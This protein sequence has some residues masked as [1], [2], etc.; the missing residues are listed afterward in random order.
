MVALLVSSKMFGVG[1]EIKVSE[2]VQLAPQL[3][4]TPN[5]LCMME[6][7][8]I[9]TL[10][11]NLFVPTTVEFAQTLL[12]KFEDDCAGKGLLLAPTK[13]W[14]ATYAGYLAK[15]FVNLEYPQSEKAMVVAACAIARWSI[16]HAAI[17]SS[18]DEA[19]L[20][21]AC[22]DAMHGAVSR[23]AGRPA[24]DPVV[25]RAH[26]AWADTVAAC[27]DA[28]GLRPVPLARRRAIQR[29]LLKGVEADATAVY[30]TTPAPAHT[31]R[32]SSGAESV[33]IGPQGLCSAKAKTETA[34][35]V[36]VPIPVRPVP[37][38]PAAAA[39]EPKHRASKLVSAP[40][41]C[42]SAEPSGAGTAFT[43]VVT[44]RTAVTVVVAGRPVVA[45]HPEASVP[46]TV[47]TSGQ[48]PFKALA[49]QAAAQGQSLTPEN[50]MELERSLEAAIA[51]SS[52]VAE[53]KEPA[54]D[55]ELSPRQASPPK[56]RNSARLAST[57]GAKKSKIRASAV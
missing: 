47:T 2:L 33:P 31:S 32:E 6:L 23:P 42:L 56:R 11:F 52:G 24:L 39:P 16:M 54:F 50:V 7:T 18:G 22:L 14:A 41:A 45:Q 46:A 40:D 3:K 30:P 37:A 44:T 10:Q 49:E 17:E 53:R 36:R 35:V 51:S 5:D 15:E 19:S 48:P 27:V 26:G 55:E 28:C 34:A 25:E 9:Q 8:L 4:L 12:S 1:I 38:T 20:L 43:A 57:A 21:E 13:G 29:S